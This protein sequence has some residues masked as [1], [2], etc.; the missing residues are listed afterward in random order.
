LINVPANDAA[1]MTNGVHKKSFVIG[2]C[3]SG[4]ANLRIWERQI[5][6][7]IGSKKR[8]LSRERQLSFA[9]YAEVYRAQQNTK[10]RCQA[11]QDHRYR[12][13]LT[14]S[15]VATPFDVIQKCQ[16]QAAIE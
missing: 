15:S 1:A 13:D 5:A 9:P 11:F 4:T 16:A 6:A 7:Q 12:Q 3:H 8:L 2:N 10:G 14:G